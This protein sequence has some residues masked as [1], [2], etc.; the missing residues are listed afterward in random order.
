MV[1][2]A[3]GITVLDDEDGVIGE[4]E[5]S[6]SGATAVEFLTAAFEAPPVIS[7][8]ES[9]FNCVPAADLATWEGYLTLNYNVDG[10]T[11]GD[12]ATFVHVTAPV[13]ANGLALH[14][15]SRFGVGDSVEALLASQPGVGADSAEYDGHAYDWVHY[16]VGEGTYLPNSDPN[17]GREAYW[18]ALASG[19]DGVITGLHSP[20]TYVDL[21]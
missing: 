10:W 1:V 7:H 20:T 14:T 18:G 6:E 11:V 2:G 5:Y 13:S 3:R 15:T 16:D 21:C 9:D 8:R 19:V 12:Q 4:L 17:W